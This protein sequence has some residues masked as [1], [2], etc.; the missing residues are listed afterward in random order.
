MGKNVPPVDL[1]PDAYPRP[2]QPN[3]S[4]R[5]TMPRPK[6]TFQ[7]PPDCLW[8]FLDRSWDDES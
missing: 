6:A 7:W 5:R 2:D 4:E 1:S 8:P 3:P